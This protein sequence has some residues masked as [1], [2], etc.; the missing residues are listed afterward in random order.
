M[1]YILLMLKISS[2]YHTVSAWNS[3]GHFLIAVV[4]TKCSVHRKVFAFHL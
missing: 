1:D 4:R 3:C 2:L